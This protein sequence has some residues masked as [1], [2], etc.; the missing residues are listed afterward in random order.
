MAPKQN[1]VR[2]KEILPL[3]Q[4]IDDGYSPTKNE[5][6][7]LSQIDII[8]ESD[9]TE[10]D[11][12]PNSISLLKNLKELNLWEV[13]IDDISV[14]AHITSLQGLNLSRTKVSD[15]DVIAN[16]INLQQLSL[17]SSEISD[18]HSLGNLTNLQHL[19]LSRTRI[20][21]LHPIGNLH[22]L[23]YLNLNGTQISNIDVLEKLEN[24][25][26]LNLSNTQISDINILSKLRSLKSLDLENT[27]ITR[28]D[29]LSSLDNLEELDISFTKVNN[30]D[31]LANLTNLQRLSL[32]R[33]P[34]SQIDGLNHLSKLQSLNLM[35]LEITDISPLE[36]LTNL[37]TLY[38]DN[39]KIDNIDILKNTTTLQT[40]SLTQ[41]D[42]SNI[43]TLAHLSNL[44]RLYLDY[45]PIHSL[46]VCLSNLPKLKYLNLSGLNLDYIPEEFL[47][48]QRPFFVNDHSYIENGIVLNQTTLSTQ[49][50]S[51]FAQPYELIKAYY[52]APKVPVNEAKVIFL[53]DGE[54]GKSY[55]IKRIKNNGQKGD[56][57]TK[58]THGIEIS[59]Y[60]AT[61]KN[62][63]SFHIN[64]WDFGGQDIMHAMHRCFLTDRTCYVVVISNRG[65]L[66]QQARYWLK[67][68]ASFTHGAPV[69]LA[70]NMWDK[71]QETGVDINRLKQE[72]P[73]L[74]SHPVF[75][76][77]KESEDEDFQPLIRAIIRQ[78]EQLDSSSL[79]F[80]A[81]W[82]AIRQ[83]LL[84]LAQNKHY[85]DKNEY[86]NICQRHE[87]D[88]P[89][90]R[91]W[92]LEWFNDL[93]V[94]FSYHQDTAKNT[95]LPTY[96]VLNPSWLTNAIYI[97]I[98]A[99]KNY[100]DNGKMLLSTM[101]LLLKSSDYGVLP[102]VIYTEAE[103]NYVLEVMRKFNLSYPVSDTQEFIPALCSSDT[104]IDLHPTEYPIHITYQ[105]DYSYLPDSVIHQLMIRF[106]P[107]LHPQK[108]WRKGMCIDYG[109][110]GLNA[111]VD[112]GNDDATLRIDVYSNGNIEPWILL[113][114]IRNEIKTINN[115][116]GIKATDHIIIHEDS[117][118]ISKTVDELLD[119]KEQGLTELQIHNPV[120]RKW[121]YRSVDEILGMTLGKPVIDEV[122]KEAK[123]KKQTLP[124]AYKTVNIEKFIMLN[125]P[126][127]SINAT[128]IIELLLQN[129]CQTN[130][131]LLTCLVNILNATGNTTAQNVAKEIKQD[132]KENKNFLQRLAESVKSIA[133]I[134]SNSKTAYEDGK[135]IGTAVM[136]ALPKLIEAA[137]EIAETLGKFLPVG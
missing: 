25:Q 75:Y 11:A 55:T 119:A 87:L 18:I 116:L 131:T 41:T 35:E 104:P 115:N 103:R 49:P 94:C 88:S 101:M 26:H 32:V 64:F 39:L 90:I 102:S 20:H 4:K 61:K 37:Q 72:Y 7:M 43:D 79:S 65:N 77:A 38:L 53:G 132:F 19:N 89:D 109:H 92:L 50:V 121:S 111:I 85:I 45:I 69:L 73:N 21:N 3:L 28:I 5:Q 42:I 6:S 123:K 97:L 124:D 110:L 76:S 107:Q 59:T 130:A 128:Q 14:L 17:N 60:P 86:H 29:A 54:V 24:L 46:P 56:Y 70:V 137:P 125:Q 48:P 118:E 84:E 133:T 135:V 81:Q 99:G 108:L 33:I 68:I 2:L 23:K 36:K 126:S 120:T 134:T 105:L 71:I 66:N 27:K 31:A 96:K 122:E 74:V 12:L 98:N 91:T 10:L 127:P 106:Y 30:I 44:E 47:D 13:Q 113:H 82:E 8:I 57:Y 78:A 52:D 95:E 58:T 114:N 80:P 16:L 15:I 83:D 67:N 63:D 51:L 9:I 40:L 22:K 34:V 129:Q 112:M 62:G 100:S 1:T 117:C 93:G 136:T